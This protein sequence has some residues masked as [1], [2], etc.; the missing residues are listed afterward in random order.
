[1][2]ITDSNWRRAFA[3][4]FFV[5]IF[6]CALT[7]FGVEK[8]KERQ[9]KNQV[10]PVTVKFF[11]A[12]QMG[13]IDVG[14]VPSSYSNLTMRVRNI[15]RTPLK[16]ELPKTFAAVPVAR[17]QAKQAMQLRGVP[18]NLSDNFG[19]N[20]GN[21]QGLGGS[22]SGPWWGASL[23]RTNANQDGEQPKQDGPQFLN[24]AP[25]R[26]AQTQIPCFCLEFGKPDPNSRIP[27]IICPLNDL[28]N[29]NAVA[30]LLDQFTQQG[31]NQYVAQLAA[32]HIA[33]DVPWQMLTKVQ[34]PRTKTSRGHRVTQ[35]ELVAA[36]RL[37]ET[38]PSYGRQA[39]L[40]GDH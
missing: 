30:E 40:G 13:Q 18:A 19:Q 26:F 20:Y 1:M 16:I 10:E 25:G 5:A 17:M 8:D 4:L 9:N 3:W 27:Y 6:A 28:N 31:I 24:L 36:R 23:A 11:T 14:V 22:L 21:S 37:A 15:C 39:S 12:I 34:F 7:S 32:W 38:L 2:D 33:N 29:K 35:M